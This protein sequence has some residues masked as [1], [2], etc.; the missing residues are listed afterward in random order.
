M[1]KSLIAAASGAAA[2]ASAGPAAPFILALTA[3]KLAMGTVAGEEGEE[4]AKVVD[5][6]MDAASILDRND[7]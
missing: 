6:A 5:L 3:G 7:D 2:A 1:V 4:A